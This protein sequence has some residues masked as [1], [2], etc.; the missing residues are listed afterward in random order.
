MI[1]SPSVIRLAIACV[2]GGVGAGCSPGTASS[3]PGV[4]DGSA[5]PLADSGLVPA[6]GD[7]DATSATN[8]GPDASQ[9]PPATSFAGP[10]PFKA[11]STGS[12]GPGGAFSLY[13]PTTLG[14][15]GV[16]HPIISWGNGTAAPTF[17]YGPLL[18]H[19]ATHGFVVVA[20]NSTQTGSG[21][22]MLDGVSWLAAEN[23]RPS[24]PLYQK[25]DLSAV[26]A[27]GH[28]QGGGGE[29]QRG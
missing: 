12:A 26:G 7:V 16:R 23:D 28:S 17:V 4:S 20:T 3:A 13:H 10:G 6:D 15:G 21:K 11:T 8:A 14:K 18:T 19:F 2:L 24:S 9:L 22:E 25:L 29:H 27:T 5:A 1:R